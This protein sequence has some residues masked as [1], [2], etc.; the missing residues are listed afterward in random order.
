[1][2]KA[3]VAIGIVVA[4]A[5]FAAADFYLNNLGRDLNFDSQGAAPVQATQP[6]T[7]T[8]IPSAFKVGDTVQGFKVMSQVMTSQ[9]FDKVD[10]GNVKNILV[11]KTQLEKVSPPVPVATEAAPVEVGATPAETPPAAQAPAP[12]PFALYEIVGPRDQ[13]ALTYLAVKLQFVAQINVTTET[14]NEDSKYG[15]NDFFY[16]DQNLQ[17]TAFLVTQIGDNLYGFQYNKNSPETYESVKS[18]IQQLTPKR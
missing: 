5:A 17:S 9:V 4:L 1:M 8:V 14:I 16:N 11:V 3:P 13:G 10:L 12:E 18:M 7:P 2:K 15:D 6:S